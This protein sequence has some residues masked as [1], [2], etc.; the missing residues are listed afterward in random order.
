MTLLMSVLI[1][2]ILQAQILSQ[3]HLKLTG[4]VDSNLFGIAVPF[5]NQEQKI[6]KGTQNVGIFRVIIMFYGGNGSN[7]S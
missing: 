3:H 1:R 5:S 4:C 6:I 2:F 7:N